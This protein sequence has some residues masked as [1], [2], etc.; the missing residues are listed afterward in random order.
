MFV[1]KNIKYLTSERC[2]INNVLIKKISGTE[3]LLIILKYIL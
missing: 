3:L 2:G 1:L